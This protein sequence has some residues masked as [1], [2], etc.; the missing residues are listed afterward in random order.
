VTASSPG[1]RGIYGSIGAVG[2][3]GL[4]HRCAVAYTDN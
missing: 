3:W 2:E 1:S 4:K